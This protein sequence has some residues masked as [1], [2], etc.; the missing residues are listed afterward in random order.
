MNKFLDAYDKPKLNQEDIKDLNS[1]ITSNEIE[2][3]I[4]ILPTKKSSGPDVFTTEFY[5]TLKKN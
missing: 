4:K 2:A 3:V 5:Q 1:P